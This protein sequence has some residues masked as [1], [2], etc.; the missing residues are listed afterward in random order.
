MYCHSQTLESLKKKTK[1][2][3]SDIYDIFLFLQSGIDG[4]NLTS[5]IFLNH[6][7]YI[8]SLNTLREILTEFDGILPTTKKLR[9]MGLNITSNDSNEINSNSLY[10]SLRKNENYILIIISNDE[11]FLKKFLSYRLY[12]S[13][14]LVTDRSEIVQRFT[15]SSINHIILVKSIKNEDSEDKE[16]IELI[17]DDQ[18]VKFLGKRKNSVNIYVKCLEGENLETFI[19]E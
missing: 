10:N 14:I 1:P 16:L 5:Q 3:T 12:N 11:K 19:F 6:S 18:I 4:F 8:N 2:S 7:N 9:R 13:I 17:K 15:L